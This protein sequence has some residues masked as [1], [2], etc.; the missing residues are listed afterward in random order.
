L[1]ERGKIYLVGAGPG[2][3][4]LITAKGLQL[5]RD[6]Q[7]VVYDRLVGQRLLREASPDAEMVNVGKAR[8]SQQLGQVEINQLLVEKAWEG[9]NVVR[10]KGGDPF[11]FGRG[12]EE[13]E[14][15]AEAGVAFEVVP[16][17]TSAIAAP[18]YAGIP[19]THRG[20]SSYVTIVSGSEDPSKVESSIDWERLASGKGTLVVL[21]GWETLPGIVDTLK[22]HGLDSATPAA[23]VQWGTEPF[24]RTVVG[25]LD[26]ILEMGRLAALTPPV[27]AIFGQVV[28]LRERIHWFDDK[29]LFGKRVLV[30]RT[31]AQAGVL[32]RLLMENG[33]DPLEIPTIEIKSME[34]HTQ[35]DAA[36]T[37][38][39]TYDWVVFASANGV[40]EAFQRL[41]QLNLDARVFG[42][43]KV[44]A[45]GPVTAAALKE[46]GILAD[47]KPRESMSEAMV[48]GL[49]EWGI[50]GKSVLLLRAEA[51]RDA[52][53][54]G[55]SREGALVKDVAVYRTVM[56]EES[57]EVVRDLVAEDGI[58]VVAFTS[59]STVSNLVA[60]LGGDATAL[61]GKTLACIG[62]I[63]AE[64]ARE[65]GLTVDVV[66]KE[67]TI[68]G[69]V[70]AVVEHF[71]TARSE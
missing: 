18:A 6:A 29:P 34:D 51:G 21:M 35:L 26:D 7:V 16:G 11:I 15:L 20:V 28:K 58:D 22:R 46:L 53:S 4:G 40:R 17:I 27:V 37:S 31:R 67:S 1:T 60:L 56:P 68:P 38:M 55:L 10:L 64:T 33:A 45:I 49:A 59:S 2:D 39:S 61:K 48:T 8:G 41:E 66:A 69:L 19:L 62:S 50:N 23:L 44:C 14:V 52:L 9:K 25:S 13:A 30:P 42:R 43:T 63:T 32:S 70:N 65:A 57:R 12:G 71:S 54:Q 5:L 47:L 3:P 24:Q 36:L